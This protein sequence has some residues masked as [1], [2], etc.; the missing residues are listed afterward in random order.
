MVHHVLLAVLVVGCGQFGDALE[1]STDP[2]RM[3]VVNLG[4]NRYV[5]AVE[6][7]DRFPANP[8]PAR[9]TQGQLPSDQEIA[10]ITVTAEYSGWAARG[11]GRRRGSSIQ[12]SEN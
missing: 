7:Y 1:R 5:Y 8:T 12:S 4:T 6:R 9:P 10:T 3:L 11:S 2:N